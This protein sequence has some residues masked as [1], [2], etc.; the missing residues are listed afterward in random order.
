MEYTT[1][2]YCKAQVKTS[3]F[4][5]TKITTQE[6]TTAINELLSIQ[7][8]AYCDKCFPELRAKVISTRERLSKEID[9][10]LYV[11]PVVTTHKPIDWEY[12]TLEI[13]TGQS[14]IGTGI[15]SEFT[16]GLTDL[17]GQ[18]S[19]SFSKKIATGERMCLSQLRAKTL[20]LGGNAVIATDIDYGEL[21][22]S[23]GMI[24]VCAAGTAVKIT[25]LSILGSR[26]QIITDMQN[27]S[28]V[29]EKIIKYSNII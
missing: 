7:N 20:K 11:I 21:G 4:T 6:Q 18:P 2:P 28:I 22:S 23:K 19:N 12:Q 5:P 9:G 3:V 15:I 25:N 27:K 26:H 16:S 8:E 24:M 1:C 13:V 14:V 29:L 10:Y 17:F